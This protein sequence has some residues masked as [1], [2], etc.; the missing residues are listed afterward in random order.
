MSDFRVSVTNK[1]DKESITVSP[2][3]A[4]GFGCCVP[5]GGTMNFSF[6]SERDPNSITLSIVRIAEGMGVK[7]QVMD[8][9][10]HGGTCK[11]ESATARPCLIKI[12]NLDAIMSSVTDV[13][14]GRR[15][16]VAN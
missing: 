12:E 13:V 2:L 11:I 5:P 7:P 14:V 9:E 3:D 1:Y 4:R 6:K 10:T 8:M 16:A 15:G